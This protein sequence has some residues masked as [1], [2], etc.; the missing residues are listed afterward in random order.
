MFDSDLNVFYSGG[1]GGFYF[2]H[3]LLMNK[4]HF[5]RFPTKIKY[6]YHPALRLPE[7][8]YNSIKDSS[9]PNYS[10]YLRHGSLDN[11]ELQNAEMQWAINPEVVPGWFDRV[12]ESVHQHNWNINPSRWKSTE[13]W[14]SNSDTLNSTC[15]LRPHKVF[16]T[17]NDI[18]S[19]LQWPGK[20]VV[21]YTDIRTQTRL[22]M[23]KKAWKYTNPEK[24]YLKTKIS[25]SS[26]KN[27]LGE[28]VWDKA[29]PALQQAD[30][31]VR[32]QDFV[33]S[34]LDSKSTQ[35]QKDFTNFWLSQHPT[36]L[37]RRC[38]LI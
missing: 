6:D 32:L 31:T 22:A 17:C 4:Q 16:F 30:Y 34:M 19:W 25:L 35:T 11:I 24:K 15:D 26:A 7:S 12:F 36:D 38:N 29:L 21:L 37:L 13:I 10:Y 1:S 28:L 3:C 27:Y 5:C 2:L 23:Y 14:P 20:K 33:K 8:S 18:E 9:W